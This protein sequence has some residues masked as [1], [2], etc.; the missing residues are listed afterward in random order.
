MQKNSIVMAAAAA[1]LAAGGGSALAHDSGGRSGNNDSR[2]GQAKGHATVL[3]AASYINRDTGAATENPDVRENSRCSRPDRRDTQRLSD[4]GTA[5][6]NVHNDACFFEKRARR[7]EAARK[8]DAPATFDSSGVGSISACPDPD[9]AGPKIAVSKDRDGDG[10]TDFCFQSGY[11]EKGMAGDREFHARLNNTTT[12][13]RQRVVWC[14]DPDRDGC[15]DERARD[16]I[17]IDWTR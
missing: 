17:A 3:Y 5:N 11:Q 6:R 10:R 9:G 13:G 14:Y 4:A 8:V 16:R 2:G 15:S 12:P 7:G 1:A